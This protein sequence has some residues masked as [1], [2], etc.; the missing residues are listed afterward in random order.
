MKLTKKIEQEVLKAYNTGWE[1]YMRGDLKTHG[2][3]LS[4]K[5]KIIGTTEAEHFN[6]KKA[7]LAFCKK[8]IHQVVGVAQ[9]RNRKIK[10][11]AVGDGVMV[12]ENSAIYV[13]IE[14]KWQFYSKIRITAL[15][16]K[17]KTGWKYVHQHGSLPDMRA[18]ED[19]TI[20]TKEIKKENQQLRE[21]VKRRTIE[22]EEKNRE[23]EIEASLEKVR[24]Q[25]LG[26]RTSEDLLH[27]CRTLYKELAALG[28][29][30][31]RNAV[32]H[33]FHDERA[34]F[35]DHE[36]SDSTG[37]NITTVPFK[38][39]ATIEKFIKRIRKSENA[40]VELKVEGKELSNWKLFRKKTGQIKDNRLKQIKAIHY[41]I[42][43]VGHASIGISSFDA[44][45]KD[46]K[47]LLKR[48]R[49]V[50]D[51]AYRRYTD[52]TLAYAQ[53]REAQIESALERVRAASLAMHKADELL[54]V[55]TVMR[56][57]MAALGVEEL[58]TSSI[59]TML[60]NDKAECWYAIKDVRGKN[61]TLVFDEMTINL[62]A[63]YVGRQ[64]LKFFKSTTPQS[65]ILMRGEQRKE[66]INYCA[67][68]SNVLKGYYGSEIPERTYHLVKFSHGYV[69]AATPGTISN[70]SWSL[71]QRM[72]AVFSLAYT[73][74]LDLQ[75][76][77]KQ[78]REA[79]IEVAVERVRA[80]A[81]AMHKSSEISALANTLRHELV[82]LNIPGVA[83]ATICLKQED[84]MI[85]SWDITST[86]EYEDE[87]HFNL[88]F[89]FNLAGTQPTDWIRRI[90]DPKRKYFVIEQDEADIHRT[91]AWTRKYNSAFADTAH[92]FLTE[93]N[94]KQ[95]WHPVVSLEY[96]KLSLDMFQPPPAET[97]PILI[98]MGAAFDLAY[99]RF[100][101]LQK[102]EA[103]ARE[104]QIEAALERVRSRSLSMKNSEELK[105]VV[106]VLFKQLQELNFGMDQGAAIVMT[107]SPDSKDHTQWITDANQSYP[108]PFFIPFTPHSISRD[109]SN[110][111]MKGLSFLSKVYNQKDKNDYFKHLFQFTEYK[112][113]PKEVKTVILKSK[114]FGISIAFENHSAIAVP[115][116]VGKLV[117]GNEIEILKRFAKVFEQC[118]TR[119]LD[120]QKAEEQAREAQIEASLERI[121]AKAM[122]IR[123]SEEWKD[124]I[125]VVFQEWNKLGVSPYECSINIIDRETRVFTNWATGSTGESD[126]LTCYKISPWNHS[127]L[128]DF[129]RDFFEGKKYRT[130]YLTGKRWTTY[131]DGLFTHSDFKDAPQAY[132]DQL[133]AVK[134][135]HVSHAN[136]YHTSLDLFDFEPLPEDKAE[137]MVRIAAVVEMAYTRYLDIK[138]AEA[139]AREA[140]IEV[141]VERV[142]AKALAMHK[143]EEIMSVIKSLRQELDGLKIPGVVGTTIYLKQDDGRIRF[144]DIT[145]LEEHED[146][147]HFTMDKYLRLEE[148]PDFLW[149][150]RLFRQE[151]KY[152][153]VGQH[154][155]ELKRSMEWI[156]QS[157]NEE[158]ALS[159][160]AF[161]E[162]TRSWHLWHPRVLLEH[163]VMNIDLIQPPPAE[164][165]PI[166]IKMGAAF[167]L[168]YKRFLDLQNAE[169]QAREAQIEAALEKVRSRSLAMHKSEEMREIVKAVF[170]R[171][172][173]LNFA[174]DGGV[175]I[176]IPDETSRTIK[177]WVGDEHAEYPTCFNLTYFDTSIIN[178][179]WNTGQEAG[180][181][182]ICRTYPCE[183]KNHWFAFAFEN[184]DFK[185]LPRELKN[186]IID[187]EFLTQ[188][189][190]MAKYS[191]IGIHFHHERILTE[192]EIDVIKRFGKVFEQGYV[193][194]LD[195]QKAEAQAR[196]AQIEAAVERVRAQSMAM[197]HPDDLDKVNKELLKQLHQLQITGLTGVT[198]YLIN[199]DGRVN[200]WDFS[201]PGNIGAPNSYTLQFDFTKYEMLGE[202][203][204]VL[205]HSDH[206]YF[207]A[208]YPLEKLKR[209][210]YEIEEINPAVGHRCKMKRWQA[211]N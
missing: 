85:R 67:S 139:Q 53:A 12:V 79:H 60:D 167:D 145:T 107:F 165:E 157:I 174:I 30:T 76:A 64:M 45:E 31:L 16:Q 80:R 114:L 94:I 132:K 175:F 109:Q 9:M 178:D 196:E 23:L 171:L 49:N 188:T 102:A 73:R 90:W 32:I 122:A 128:N 82:G 89:V 172:K 20:A 166:L 52:I 142:R 113:L 103:Q 8:T 39:D 84:G 124:I 198:F 65:S 163:G 209:A 25:A 2:A 56:T 40:F 77:E 41:Y 38:G 185:I 15:L 160:I 154:E 168:A 194:F 18:S 148:C 210:V 28:F 21:A 19:E 95:V 36:Y 22:L 105:E 144:W 134:T 158:V 29:D 86:V 98:K 91:I 138:T 149:F 190:A 125:R 71:L 207:I 87:F 24:A 120:L 162:E 10:L 183:V 3:C 42:Y 1:A 197:H 201:S 72:T 5:F 135:I 126:A 137:V 68:C 182:F 37:G 173:E 57:E 83:A 187:Q 204:R 78:A 54:Q 115:S 70:E 200:A 48:F 130:D 74:F 146:G 153:I 44:I 189:F 193:R 195:L 6:S 66:W 58:E 100:L 104:A 101:D 156:R 176:A 88:D 26:M 117:S 152:L 61:S 121:R 46:K 151:E 111:R 97:E 4:S 203:F 34:C 118:Y 186:W 51:F 81:L 93:N 63:T 181:N 110:A 14:G 50:F 136:N 75:K 180:V 99:K 150:Q 169:A 27:I 184:T 69:G 43:S 129:Y 47:E 133:Y 59:Y 206:N 159:M 55:A 211:G 170:E 191:G 192:N 155:E 33:V 11:E 131:L 92:R 119:F 108:V 106:A 208:D 161:F 141:A 96:G 177:L 202:P 147:A 199:E 179:I 123:K 205:L 112:H 140:Q 7:W 143:S 17:E 35:T 164:A 127:I 13:L 116:T 62:K